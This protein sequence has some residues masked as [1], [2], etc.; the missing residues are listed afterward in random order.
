MTRVE[1]QIAHLVA[2]YMDMLGVPSSADPPWIEVRDNVGAKWLA[3]T[4]WRSS[5]PET[6]TIVVQRKIL[7]VPETLER[8][9][10]HEVIHHVQFMKM[11]K[12]DLAMLKLGRK[13]LSSGHGPDFR[14]MAEKINAI[15][16]E[17]FVTEKS[18]ETYDVP[19]SG[20]KIFVLIEPVPGDRLGWAWGARLS[21][22]MEAE[23]QSRSVSTA[24]VALVETD[25]DRFIHGV[26][27]KKY[28]GR[29]IPPK[30]SELETRLREL[31]EEAK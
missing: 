2:D 12:A 15:K 6:T 1:E 24:G 3:I 8:A 21:P 16:G 25:D 14:Q 29:S 11:T 7:D 31:Y 5:R 10:A 4:E 30:G 19:V 27:I 26:K 18:D 23:I 17:G 13:D 28:G 22:Q 20:K 9:V